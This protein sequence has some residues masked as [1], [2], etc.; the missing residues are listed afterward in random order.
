MPT[1]SIT[2]DLPA[3]WDSLLHRCG[4]SNPFVSAA[5]YNALE[6]SGSAI[7]DTGWSRR[8]F[9]LYDNDAVQGDTLTAACVCYVK[10]HSY[11][12]YVF[13]WAWADAYA[14]HG[15]AYFPKLLCAVPYTPVP[16]PRIIAADDAVRQALLQAMIDDAKTLGLSSVHILF[17]EVKDALNVQQTQQTQKSKHSQHE[18]YLQR[19]GVQFHWQ[20]S[21]PSYKNFDAFLA[22]MQRD[23]RKKILAER[24]KV[25]SK[26]VSWR[27]LQG[28]QGVQGEITAQD[29]AFFYQ[30][31]A[32]TYAE[33]GRQT[34]YLTPAF[35]T[36]TPPSMWVMFVAELE[37]NKAVGEKEGAFQPIAA[38]LIAIDPQTKTAYGRYWGSLFHIDCLHF[39]ACYYQP[40][41]WCIANEYNS[42]EGGAQGEH[43]M[44]R[45]LLPTPTTSLHWL[46]HP[47][48][49]AA[50]ARFLE[51]ESAGIAAYADDLSERSPMRPHTVN[52]N[53]SH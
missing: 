22:N 38:S 19:H 41:S 48:F 5:Y 43:K 28:D 50:V 9:A 42:F 27:V 23:K 4:H 6:Q 1:L 7:A 49:H 31:Y 13:D 51:R 26:G 24:R 20:N 14:Q 30:C 52:A 2:A 47:Q 45:G 36:Q 18:A 40:L 25:A 17:D 34:P 8:V 35:F 33:H 39:E 12:E 29:W 53:D 15:L 16:G 3:A 46:S 10:S 21:S 11:G 37:N 32:Q 44:A